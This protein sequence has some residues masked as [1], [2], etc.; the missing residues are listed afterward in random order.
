MSLRT[1]YRHFR[2]TD[3]LLLGVSDLLLA[4]LGGTDVSTWDSAVGLLRAQ[5]RMFEEDP[6]VFRV[7]FSVPTRSRGD[8][9]GAIRALFADRVAH[10]PPEER[11]RRFALVDLLT[12]PYGWDVLTRNWGLSADDAL[13]TALD[14]VN[15]LLPPPEPR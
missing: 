5:W 10:L 7:W 14:A 15:R 4:R 1:V 12:S 11:E 2:T 13:Q 8:G 3:A 6:A 9:N